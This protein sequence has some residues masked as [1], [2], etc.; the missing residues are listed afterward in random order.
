[1]ALQVLHKL[2][3]NELSYSAIN[4]AR[5][6]LSTIL[7]IEGSKTFG[8]HPVVPTYSKGVFLNRKLVPK[9]NSVWDVSSQIPQNP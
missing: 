1:M 6:A 5:A 7:T 3:E 9:C 4:T 2:Y 8:T